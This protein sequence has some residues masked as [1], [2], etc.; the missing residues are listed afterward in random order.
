MLYFQSVGT[1]GVLGLR[2]KPRYCLGDVSELFCLL[3]TC[4]WSVLGNIWMS[5]S[6]H[7]TAPAALSL[8]VTPGGKGELQ[9]SLW[10]H[11][12][13]LEAALHEPWTD[14]ICSACSKAWLRCLFRGLTAGCPCPGCLSDLTGQTLLS[15]AG[16]KLHDLEMQSSL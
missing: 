7:P 8:E 4:W 2:A 13:P 5:L 10:E 15:G 12:V 1:P 9:P 3:P 14:S 6:Q 11:Q 16:V